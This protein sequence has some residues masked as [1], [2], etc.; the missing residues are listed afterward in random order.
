MRPS[1]LP[2]NRLSGGDTDRRGLGVTVRAGVDGVFNN[3][4]DRRRIF[5]DG[6][7]ADGIVKAIDYRNICNRQLTYLRIVDTF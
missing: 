3:G 6:S 2:S 5:Y 4:D 7:R 1:Y